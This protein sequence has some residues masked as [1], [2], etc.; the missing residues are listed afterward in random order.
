MDKCKE[1]ILDDIVIVDILK[2]SAVDVSIPPTIPITS[3]T[4]TSGMFGTP[5]ISAGMGAD[6]GITLAD[7]ANLHYVNSRIQA[8]NVY[9][10]DFTFSVLSG[11]EDAEK[12]VNELEGIPI[13]I[14]CTRAS[15]EK[16]LVYALPNATS[17]DID[18]TLSSAS[19]FTIK[20]KILSMSGPIA[21]IPAS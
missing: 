7:K 18:T 2:A 9:T 15:G 4:E 20:A 5:H 16:F 21:I 19:A 13:H 10:H 11:K 8:G 1:S 3:I 14:V 12:M 17:V 6:K